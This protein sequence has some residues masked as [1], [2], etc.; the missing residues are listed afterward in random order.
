[1]SQEFIPAILNGDM[2]RPREMARGI[3]EQKYQE[4]RQA[5]DD[6]T[7]LAKDS[8]KQ[9]EQAAIDITAQGTLLLLAIGVSIVAIV[10]LVSGFIARG[11]MK[12]RGQAAWVLKDIAEGDGDLSGLSSNW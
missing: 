5:I 10:C 11:I 1:M 12:P 2:Y 7:K 8:N 3:L 9:D 4:H 6:V